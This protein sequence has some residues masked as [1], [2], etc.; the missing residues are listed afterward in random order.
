MVP[1]KQL[2]DGWVEMG[3]QTGGVI[4]LV[5]GLGSFYSLTALQGLLLP[6]LALNQAMS[7]IIREASDFR[8]KTN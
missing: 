2:I 6:P 3:R 4:G 1:N 7:G 5:I 8:R